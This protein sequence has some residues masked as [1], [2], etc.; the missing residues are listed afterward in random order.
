VF[1]HRI[2]DHL[3]LRMLRLSDAE[4]LFAL[5]DANRAWLRAWLP[6]LDGN[7]RVEDSR[8]FIQSML[9]QY[10]A[11]RG[12]DCAILENGAIVGTVEIKVVEWAHG[13]AEIGYMLAADAG[14]RGVMTR[15]CRVLIDY[16]FDELEV[17]KLMIRAATGNTRSRAVAERL[18]FTQEGVLRDAEW[19]YDHWVDHAV[20]GL[21]RRQWA[22]GDAHQR[23]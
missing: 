20:Y 17:N 4:E 11:S 13:C 14:G 22:S 12:F 8:R 7:T 2:D 15:A 3:A 21:L 10:A 9:D 18:G 1:A 23:L 16:A 19:L 5:T 6:W